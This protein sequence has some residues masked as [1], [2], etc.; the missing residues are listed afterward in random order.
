M[1]GLTLRLSWCRRS[2]ARRPVL[3][4]AF[5]VAII[6]GTPGLAGATV[7]SWHMTHAYQAPIQAMTGVDCTST[8]HCVATTTNGRIVTTTN[9]WGSITSVAARGFHLADQMNSVSC[10]SALKCEAIGTWGTSTTGY[11]VVMGS[12]N[13]GHS[14]VVQHASPVPHA[15]ESITCA[16]VAVCMAVGVMGGHTEYWIRTI[17][18]GAHWSDHTGTIS[19]SIGG[20]SSVSCS[21]QLACTVVG[22]RGVGAFTSNGGATWSVGTA[23]STVNWLYSVK[24]FA[25]GACF[26]AGEDTKHQGLNLYSSNYGITW[27]FATPSAAAS[28]EY[29]VSC[30]DTHHC[31]VVGQSAFNKGVVLRTTNGVTWSTMAIPAGTTVLNAIVCR[32][33]SWCTAVGANAANNAVVLTLH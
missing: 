17:D 20:L 23:F 8:L 26:G 3:V 11:G 14:W 12:T 6:V 1:D 27:S 25:Q 2:L 29:G 18:G 19:P 4:S 33:V 31:F 7:P 16:S 21:S 15:L 30:V 22:I 24:C 10:P 13:G 32:S 28:H 5:A 9:G